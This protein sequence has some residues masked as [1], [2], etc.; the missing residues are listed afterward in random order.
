ME[1]II[2]SNCEY[3]N[4]LPFRILER[5]FSRGSVGTMYK[6]K[7]GV[8]KFLRIHARCCNINT[9]SKVRL[10][11]GAIEK[12]KK[13]MEAEDFLFQ[14]YKFFDGNTE[15]LV[16]IDETWKSRI[17]VNSSN[18]SRQRGRSWYT[19]CGN[20]KFSVQV[21][22]K[23]FFCSNYGIFDSRILVIFHGNKERLVRFGSI[24]TL[25]RASFLGI[26]GDQPSGCCQQR[27]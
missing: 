11:V 22:L 4:S 27:W 17:L 15:K 18:F 9:M 20:W 12:K 21:L 13:S 16:I 19:K 26:D 6:K 8:E 5:E 3:G 14:F 1:A 2:K 23:I 24:A 10:I 7:K 25:S